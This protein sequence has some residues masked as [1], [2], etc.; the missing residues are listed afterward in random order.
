MVLRSLLM[1]EAQ[2]GL[3]EQT[4]RAVRY[5]ITETAQKLFIERGYEATT[6]DEIATAVGMS[7]RSFHRY[8]ANKEDIVVGK[9]DFVAEQM[10]TVLRDRPE[11]EPTWVSLRRLFDLLVDYV[12]A[13][14]KQQVA[15]PMQRMV[16]ATP[17]LLASYLEKLQRLQ[18]AVVTALCERAADRGE[19]YAENDPAPRAVVAAAFGCLIA[20]QHAWLAGAGRTSFADT[21]DRAMGAVTP[22]APVTPR[23]AAVR[24]RAPK[25][26]RT[27]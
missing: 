26:T 25:G 23:S 22:T 5:H 16:F 3:R 20:A 15:D 11:N 18:E 27:S 24:R 2:V 9:F 13:P 12:D 6:I 4:R 19:P 10:L 14:G 17:G 1:S 7:R 8:F 21:I